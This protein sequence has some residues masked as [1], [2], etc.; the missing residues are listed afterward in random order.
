MPNI[1]ASTYAVMNKLSTLGSGIAGADNRSLS[2]K[3]W[4]KCGSSYT[5][6]GAR[7]CPPISYMQAN[8]SYS[9]WTGTRTVTYYT[10]QLTLT[11]EARFWEHTDASLVPLVYIT[12]N[13]TLSTGNQFTSIGPSKPLTYEISY[14][15]L[16]NNGKYT[17]TNGI[18][19][20]Y[21]PASLTT[22]PQTS[23]YY[24]DENANVTEAFNTRAAELDYTV[25]SGTLGNR[26]ETLTVN[27]PLSN[28]VTS[29]TLTFYTA[30]VATIEGDPSFNA[31]D[32]Y[33]SYLPAD[34]NIIIEGNFTGLNSRSQDAFPIP[35]SIEVIANFGTNSETLFEAIGRNVLSYIN[36]HSFILPIIH[37]R[38][39]EFPYEEVPEYPS[40]DIY[41][42]F[43]N[44]NDTVITS[45]VYTK[46]F[47]IPFTNA[48]QLVTSSNCQYL[49]F[50]NII[51]IQVEPR[52]S[53][54]KNITVEETNNR[55]FEWFAECLRTSNKN[56]VNI[57]C[58]TLEYG[59]SYYFNIKLYNHKNQAT[60]F[61]Q[62]GTS[63]LYMTQSLYI[64]NHGFSSEGTDTISNTADNPYTSVNF[65]GTLPT[66]FSGGNVIA[67][68]GITYEKYEKYAISQYS[69]IIN[70]NYERAST[71]TYNIYYTSTDSFIS[72]ITLQNLGYDITFNTGGLNNNIYRIV[73][74]QLI[75]ADDNGDLA[76][77]VSWLTNDNE[78]NTLY[79]AT[80][81]LKFVNKYDDI[82]ET[83]IYPDVTTSLIGNYIRCTL[84]PGWPTNTQYAPG[85]LDG[86]QMS[87]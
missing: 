19:F 45:N 59:V 72:N 62:T 43:T 54:I 74:I 87:H 3:I 63:G 55:S 35:K 16:D 47:I 14:D 38:T 21:T 80:F 44:Y 37:E 66:T 57:F 40:R 83:Q 33:G 64:N 39:T 79:K 8:F 41:I 5:S 76:V 25:K 17:V 18:I 36:G 58:K 60:T 49:Y 77:P 22:K 7:Y 50:S 2:K 15:Y 10:T 52:Y 23:Y 86:P 29:N 67:K 73:N 9:Y 6:L 46:Y 75:G 71:S 78:F 34:T 48:V 31:T 13:R 84:E 65:N 4:Q 69:A 28:I 20:N 85:T 24:T 11:D 56:I 30:H 51:T 68:I 32:V 12:T 53:F 61:Q 81:Y 27:A 82:L 70:V 42:R 1:I 26:V